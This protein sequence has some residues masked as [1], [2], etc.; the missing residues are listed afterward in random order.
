MSL[1][2]I[3]ILPKQKNHHKFLNKVDWCLLKK[4]YYDCLNKKILLPKNYQFLSFET[5]EKC[6]N[7]NNKQ[8]HWYNQF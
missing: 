8:I 1:N 4:Y 2:G 3:S 7:D 6:E 5:Y